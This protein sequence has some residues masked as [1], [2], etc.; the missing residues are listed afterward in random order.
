MD[1]A[2]FFYLVILNLI[3]NQHHVYAE[4]WGN[5]K[6]E[7]ALIIDGSDNDAGEDSVRPTAD[8]DLAMNVTLDW[9]M[10][11]INDFDETN[12]YIDVS[13]FITLE[14]IADAYMTRTNIDIIEQ[15]N[16]NTIWKPP[17]VL[18]NS[19]KTYEVIGHDTSVTVRYIFKTK[20]CQWKPWV[21]AR[22]ACSPDVQYYPFDKQS[23][24]FR[25]SVWGY[26]SDEVLLTSKNKEWR[27][28]Y[29]E[30]NG[31]WEIDDSSVETAIINELSVIDFKMK[32]TRRPM[33][34]IINLIS[35]VVLLSALSACT[36]LLP[37]DSGEL[38]SLSRVS[39]L[40]PYY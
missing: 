37:V 25:L 11:Y 35:P 24:A 30:K 26:K 39:C 16:P 27:F 28:L 33:Y 36:F 14:W 22:A 12:G 13:G 21:V 38:D 9:N 17:I 40:I 1:V 10:V 8:S 15:L 32:M 3:V 34:Y 20:E 31:E 18:V 23:C 29:F 7:V 6:S 4:T 5:V 19:V 2:R